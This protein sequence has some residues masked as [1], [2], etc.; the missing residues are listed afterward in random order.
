MSQTESKFILVGG[1][2][3]VG[4][5]ATWDARKT[6]FDPPVWHILSCRFGHENIS[7]AIVPLLLIE[8]EQLSVNCIRHHGNISM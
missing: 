5:D 1:S 8:E 2:N 4:S 7:T 6:M 3:L